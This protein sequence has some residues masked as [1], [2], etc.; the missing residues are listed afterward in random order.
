MRDR[1]TIE[2]WFSETYHY[3]DVITALVQQNYEDL[4]LW[5]EFFCDNRTAH[6]IEPYKRESAL[7]AF[8]IHV[9]NQLLH[10]Q[11]TETEWEERQAIARSL[12]NVPEAL[13]DLELFILP[14]E[15]AMI[16]R[17]LKHQ[18]FVEWLA[19][20]GTTLDDASVDDVQSYL[21]D[22][23]L[24]GPYEELVERTAR[25]VFF[26]IFG[27]RR[28]LL[29]FNQIVAEKVASLKLD[30]LDSEQLEIATKRLERPGVLHRAD[31][32]EWVRRAVFFR[33]RGRCAACHVDLSGIVSLW[34]EKNFDHVVPLASGG[35]NDVTNIQLL[36]ARCNQSKGDGEPFTS[37]SYEDWY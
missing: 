15:Q 18:T 1:P 34:S 33:D 21:S 31:P 37:G 20:Q 24:Y 28:L 27:N 2:P 4:G 32:P 14:V 10:D 36:C 9:I 8:I 16:R 5:D 19:E 22:L 13:E 6:L 11:P 12:E 7:H 29:Q 17:G 3:A 26:T 35:L 25:E 23:G 30:E